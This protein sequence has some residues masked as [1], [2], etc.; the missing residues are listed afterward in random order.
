MGAGPVAVLFNDLVH[1]AYEYLNLALLLDGNGVY[2]GAR[3][4]RVHAPAFLR[5]LDAVG[6]IDAAISVASFRGRARRLDAVRGSRA[7]ARAG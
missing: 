5:V 3:R 7:P 1:V 2:F 4:L 6:E